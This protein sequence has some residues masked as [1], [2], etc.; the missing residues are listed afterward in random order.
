VTPAKL[1]WLI[2]TPEIRAK[3]IEFFGGEEA[4]ALQIAKDLREDTQQKIS[5]EV[6]AK[7]LG[8]DPGTIRRRKKR[9]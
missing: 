1:R 8:V 5:A 4:L 3:A 7:T 2:A 6:E 9:Q